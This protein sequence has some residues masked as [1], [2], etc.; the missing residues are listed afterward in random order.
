MIRNII[1]LSLLAVIVFD[2][3]SNDFLEI[4]SLGLDKIQELVY[5]IRSEVN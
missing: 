1:I 4:V 3:S 5:N 2:M